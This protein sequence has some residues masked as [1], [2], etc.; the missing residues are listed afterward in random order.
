[1]NLLPQDVVVAV[2]F[3]LDRGPPATL[4]GMATQLH[5]SSSSQ[6]HAAVSRALAARLLVPVDSDARGQTTVANC[7]N[8]LE[9]LVHGVK[10]AFPAER[11][12]LTRGVPTLGGADIFRSTFSEAEVPVVW[13]HPR[14]L[15]R[16]EGLLP[17]HRCIPEIALDAEGALFHDVFA[18]VD[19]LRAGTARERAF[20]VQKLP[21]IL[22][23]ARAT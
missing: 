1:M 21:K 4:A 11:T 7:S 20:A 2:W 23:G 15:K 16:G 13:P 18:M 8:L 17:L 9:F 6:V 22:L 5:L 12:G 14:G 10:Y 3:A 19:A